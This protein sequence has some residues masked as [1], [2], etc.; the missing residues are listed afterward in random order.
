M[1]VATNHVFVDFENVPGIDLAPIDG[2]PVRV[3][4][5]IGKRQQKLPLGLVRHIHRLAGSVE[6]VEVGASGR[7]ALDLT[8]ACYLGRAV[9]ME[10]KAAYMIV[11]RDRDFD[12]MIAHLKENGVIVSRHESIAELPFLKGSKRAGATIPRAKQTE[13]APDRLTRLATQ[14]R[15]KST[16]RPRTRARMLGRISAEFGGKLSDDEKKKKLDELVGMGVFT[17]EP[18]GRIVYKPA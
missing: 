13:P 4:L 1:P 5:L 7:N 10:P 9:E 16:S 14:L 12:P 17:V 6:L 11:S 8:L 3:T 15:G 18:S 2:H